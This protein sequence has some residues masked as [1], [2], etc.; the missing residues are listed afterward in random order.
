[1]LNGRKPEVPLRAKR[2]AKRNGCGRLETD[3]E[4]I[5]P[6]HATLVFAQTSICGTWQDTKTGFGASGKLRQV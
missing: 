2:F 3:R 5:V 1:M 4:A 6:K